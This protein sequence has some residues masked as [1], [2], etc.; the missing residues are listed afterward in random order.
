M[1]GAGIVRDGCGRVTGMDGRGGERATGSVCACDTMFD[2]E[3]E[4]EKDW[5][6]MTRV[7]LFGM[8]D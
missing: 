6:A 3:S 5:A 4:E 7:E 2:C 8:I 1:T